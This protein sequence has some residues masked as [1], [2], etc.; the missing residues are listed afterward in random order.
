MDASGGT[1][2]VPQ[3]HVVV[4]FLEQFEKKRHNIEGAERNARQCSSDGGT[5]G[6]DT[7]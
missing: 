3:A 6:V 5:F 2:D 1:G 4:W 7:C